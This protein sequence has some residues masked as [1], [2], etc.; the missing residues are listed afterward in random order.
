M[1]NAH[2]ELQRATHRELVAEVLRLRAELG[3]QTRVSLITGISKTLQVIGPWTAMVLIAFF[4]SQ[5]VAEFA[6]KLT[7][8][9]AVVEAD[10]SADAKISIKQLED[11]RKWTIGMVLVFFLLFLFGVMFGFRQ[12]QLRIIAV[13]R[14]HPYQLEYERQ[15]DPNRTSSDLMKG[16]TNP[17]D[18]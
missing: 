11:W 10:V 18:K 9:E 15:R 16:G 1:S 8:V 12:R 14:L 5:A 2:E 6:G 4:T 3:A 7:T 17:G 13:D